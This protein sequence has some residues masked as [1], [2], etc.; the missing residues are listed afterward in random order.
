METIF[1]ILKSRTILVLLFLVAF[2]TFQASSDLIN[3][4]IF[5]IVN[6]VFL[7]LAGYFRINPQAKFDE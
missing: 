5:G 3:P 6:S 4:S 7:T 1:S 2:N